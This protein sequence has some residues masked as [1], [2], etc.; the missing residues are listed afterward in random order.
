M[1]RASVLLQNTYIACLVISQ[2]IHFDLFSPS[3]SL[4]CLQRGG[5]TSVINGDGQAGTLCPRQP[6]AHYNTCL[7]AAV[8]MITPE[9]TDYV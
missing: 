3:L 9:N 6:H 7:R 4:G 2:G 8:S 5:I 1:F